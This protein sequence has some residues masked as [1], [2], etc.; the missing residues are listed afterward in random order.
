MSIKQRGMY[1]VSVRPKLYISRFK[2]KL[3][4]LYLNW[5][6]KAFNIEF[7]NHE[8]SAVPYKKVEENISSKSHAPNLQANLINTK[9]CFMCCFMFVLKLDGYQSIVSYLNNYKLNSV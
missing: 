9:L 2:N 7:Y 3:A 1:N 8:Q 5:T 4:T 6:A